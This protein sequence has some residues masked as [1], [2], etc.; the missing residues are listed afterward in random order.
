VLSVDLFLAVTVHPQPKRVSAAGTPLTNLSV[1]NSDRIFIAS[2][3]WNNEIAIRT[4]WG[5]AVLDLVRYFGPENVYISIIES[6]SWDGSKDALRELDLH[7]EELGVQRSVELIE[8]THKDDIE[9]TPE[10]GGEGQIWTNRGG[11]ELRRIPYLAGIR[12]RVMEK[13]NELADDSN[14]RKGQ[15]FERVLWL[16][17][18][19]FT[20]YHHLPA[21]ICICIMY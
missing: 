7:L 16:N 15:I 12:N 5:A 9:R 13:L 6:G 1:I 3:H 19:V 18:V 4:Y 10:P 8:S 21:L 11:K 17:D 2:M 14:E 20:V